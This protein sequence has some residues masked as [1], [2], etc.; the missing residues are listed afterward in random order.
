MLEAASAPGSGQ[1]GW[2]SPVSASLSLFWLCI[3][4][5]R[6]GGEQGQCPPPCSLTPQLPLLIP[7][8]STHHLFLLETHS[9]TTA[10]TMTTTGTSIPSRM[11]AEL[12]TSGMGQEGVE[13]EHL[14]LVFGCHPEG[15]ASP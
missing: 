8:P 11:A 13:G 7:S 10:S 3:F 14:L 4:S 12:D 6:D 1:W 2:F 5:L 15:P 9:L